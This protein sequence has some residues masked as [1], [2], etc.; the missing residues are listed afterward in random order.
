MALQNRLTRI[1]KVLDY[2]HSNLDEPIHVAS[3]AITSASTYSLAANTTDATIDTKKGTDKAFFIKEDQLGT[4]EVKGQTHR[5][6]ATKTQLDPEETPQGISIIDADS[7]KQRGIETVE[8]AVRYS[9]GINTEL[10]GGAETYYSGYDESNCWFGDQ[11]SFEVSAH[12]E[13]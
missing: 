13:F 10:R 5:N 2:I 4:L 1:K 12:Y 8:E 7:F 9:S 3:L 6:T 11:R